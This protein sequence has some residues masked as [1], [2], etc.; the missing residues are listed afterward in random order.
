MKKPSILFLNRVYPP[1]DGATGQLLAELAP[2]LVRR[3]HRVTVVT[4][5][6]G[7]GSVSSETVDGVRVERVTGLPFTR[8]SHWRRALSYFSLY[9]ALL[10]RALRI[11]LNSDASIA[12]RKTRGI[13]VT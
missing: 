4:S 3:G 12:P 10:W 7:D 5:Q 2:E 9:P 1:A 11:P 8:A 13:I 6:P